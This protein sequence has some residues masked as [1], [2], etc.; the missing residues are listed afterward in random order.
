MA[1]CRWRWHAGRLAIAIQEHMNRYAN[2]HESNDPPSPT[3]FIDDKYGDE[4]KTWLR[5]TIGWELI[6]RQKIAFRLCLS[7]TGNVGWIQ[8]TSLFSNGWDTHFDDRIS[9]AHAAMQI[10]LY[11]G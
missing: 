10:K 6:V 9:D 8:H 4:K 1:H 11:L 3:V 5:F 2:V 7:S